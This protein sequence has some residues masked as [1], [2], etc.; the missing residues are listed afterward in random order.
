M[1]IYFIFENNT[2][3]CELKKDI[4]ITFLYDIVSKKIQ[5]DKSNFD[6]YY[7]NK[8]LTEKDPTLFQISKNENSIVVIISL[9]KNLGRNSSIILAKNMKLPLLD[10]KNENDSKN[11]Q[12][13]NETQISADSLTKNTNK[14]SNLK[15]RLNPAPSAQR[16]KK[17][18]KSINKVF[19]DVYNSNEEEINNLMKDLKNKILEVDDI[20]YKSYKNSFNRDNSQLLL[21]E[22]NIINYKEKQKKFLKQLINYFE[23]N[24]A[25]FLS[26][27]KINLDDLYL[28]LSNYYY[29]KNSPIQLDITKKEKMLKNGLKTS[30][31]S[32]KKLP[33]IILTKNTEENLPHSN[34]ISEDSI[35]SDEIVKEKIDKYFINRKEK[36]LFPNPINS[37]KNI[38]NNTEPNIKIFEDETPLEKINKKSK[39]TKLKLGNINNLINNENTKIS[40]DNEN[41]DIKF[42]KSKSFIIKEEAEE[43]RE[44][45]KSFDKNKINIL[46]E[47]S[48]AN[49]E[50]TGTYSSDDASIKENAAH[51]KEKKKT[52][53]KRNSVVRK[54][55]LNY[56]K[57]KNSKFGYMV[58]IKDKK[59]AHKAKKFGNNLSDFII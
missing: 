15:L 38:I 31:Y 46:F 36:N 34:K 17:E 21:F 6:L 35:Y 9:K 5:K 47:I 55:T 7:N 45:N 13:L 10:L 58:D 54:S 39:F 2:F 8:K 1:L 30:N 14:Y 43:E 20:L 24:E 48:E 56:I 33:K 18:Y 53:I 12:F 27:G 37:N 49:H 26:M 52:K 29:N 57:F 42:P 51:L 59:K 16:R 19:E 25:I 41:I 4:S 44:V 28:E 23:T 40:K 11:N 3:T 32:E 22:K 50:N